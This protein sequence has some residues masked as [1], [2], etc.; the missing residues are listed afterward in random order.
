MLPF[1]RWPLRPKSAR[2]HRN[3]VLSRRALP[4]R[5][6]TDG[7][8]YFRENPG[9]LVAQMD[10]SQLILAAIFSSALLL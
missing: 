2:S 8:R 4:L 7:S 5:S 6:R 1:I 10:L 9:W 3:T